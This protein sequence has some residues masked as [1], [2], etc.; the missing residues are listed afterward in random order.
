[1]YLA[2]TVKSARGQSLPRVAPTGTARC[3]PPD[4]Y[5]AWSRGLRCPFVASVLRKS[6]FDLIPSPDPDLLCE[7]SNMVEN[8][9]LD[10]QVFSLQSLRR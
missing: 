6:I 4:R 2:V 1:M 10:G 9:E 8:P 3:C 7:E 5:V